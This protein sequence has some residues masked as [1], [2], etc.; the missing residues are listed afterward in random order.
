MLVLLFD[1]ARTRTSQGSAG[2]RQRS[3]CLRGPRGFMLC[4]THLVSQMLFIP[5]RFNVLPFRFG[6]ARA[7]LDE[8]ES[9]ENRTCKNGATTSSPGVCCSSSDTITFRVPYGTDYLSDFR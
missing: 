1:S 8:R 5:L 7:E 2:Q 6:T 4:I 3:F 9:V